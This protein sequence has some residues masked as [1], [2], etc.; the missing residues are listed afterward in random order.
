MRTRRRR[1]TDVRCSSFDL[2]LAEF[3]DGTLPPQ[4][5]ARVLDHVDSCERCSGLLEELRVVD[6]LLLT[7][8]L[9]E[10]AANFTFRTM[11]EV[12]SA[13]PPRVARAST[14]GVV[15]AYLAFA[16]TIIG[17]WLLVGGKGARDG[18][19]TSGETFL[20]YSGL[21]SLTDATSRLFGHATFGVTALMGAIVGV[22]LVAGIVLAVAYTAARPR[23]ARRLARMTETIG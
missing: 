22:D 11:A 7:P 18:L 14:L 4:Q 19:A 8:R 23:L 20:N 9:M 16:W 6:A 10:P 3:V 5:R 12:H 1:G 21:N 17:V 13:A 2:L 15:V